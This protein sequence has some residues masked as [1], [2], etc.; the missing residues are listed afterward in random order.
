[1]RCLDSEHCTCTTL[2][3]AITAQSSLICRFIIIIF[4]QMAVKRLEEGA[5]LPHLQK[6]KVH[7]S[8]GAAWLKSRR[9]SNKE[10]DV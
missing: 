7:T 10:G 9:V 2:G 1:M 5:L 4:Q 6:D 3:G 8:G